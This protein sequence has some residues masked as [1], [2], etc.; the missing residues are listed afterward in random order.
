MNGVSSVRRIERNDVVALAVVGLNCPP[1]GLVVDADDTGIEIDLYSWITSHFTAGRMQ[2]QR[3]DIRAVVWADV[4][5]EDDDGTVVY[6][7]DALGA[8][9]RARQAA[10]CRP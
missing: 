6:D 3:R 4:E 8:F 7:M 2:L 5:G 1:V 10:G 9:Q